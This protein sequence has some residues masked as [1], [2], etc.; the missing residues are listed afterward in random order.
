MM[1]ICLI[2]DVCLYMF[3]DPL[4]GCDK[5]IKKCQTFADSINHHPRNSAALS[6]APSTPPENNII[7]IH[8]LALVFYLRSTV[9]EMCFFSVRVKGV[10]LLD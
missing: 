8:L 7:Y 5:R 4:R 10:C 3:V 1:Y 6:R 9:R 2:L